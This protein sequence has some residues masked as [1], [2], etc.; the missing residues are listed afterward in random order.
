MSITHKASKW[1]RGRKW[2]LFNRTFQFDATTRI[3]D[4]GF[5]EVEYEEFGLADTANWLEKN[6][7]H[8]DQVTALSVELD[9][10]KHYDL[11]AERLAAERA[12]LPE[13]YPGLKLV[14][15]PGGRMP[16]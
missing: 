6:Y 9:P 12:S 1:N 4:A 11:D 2:E 10:A 16:F 7:R 14:V 13:R 3:L 15:Y 8:L 5:S